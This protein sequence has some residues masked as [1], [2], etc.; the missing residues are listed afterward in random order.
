MPLLA[1]L[2]RRARS[3]GKNSSLLILRI[4]P[5]C[6]SFHS[7]L[8]NCPLSGSATSTLLLFSWVSER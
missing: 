7:K 4:M 5:T 2:L 1:E 6:T 8:L 3:A